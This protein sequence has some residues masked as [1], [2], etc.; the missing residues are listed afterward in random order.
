MN[1]QVF[2]CVSVYVI[3]SVYVHGKNVHKEIVVSEA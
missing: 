1:E 2:V 3:A